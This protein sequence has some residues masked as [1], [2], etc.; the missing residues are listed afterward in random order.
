MRA[1]FPAENAAKMGKNSMASDPASWSIDPQLARDSVPLGNL[2]LC[3]VR[4]MNDANY[5]WLLLIP[6]CANATEIIDLSETDQA[7]LMR[8]I[9]QTV[10]A[11]KT[12]TSCHKINVAAIGNV[13][14]QLHVHVVARF[15]TDTAWPKPIWGIAPA[16]AYDDATLQKLLAALRARLPLTPE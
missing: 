10:R 2:P 16:R 13:V 9:T 11:L 1:N 8:E 3:Q 4:L 6:R 14:A 15:R 12:E 5:P 7:D